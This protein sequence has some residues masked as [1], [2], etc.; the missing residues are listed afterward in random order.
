MRIFLF[1]LA[2]IALPVSAAPKVVASVLPL[3]SLLSNVMQGVGE[4]ELL[5]PANQSPHDFHLRPSQARQLNHADLVV[6]VGNDL[7][8]SLVKPIRVLTDSARVL[9]LS[10]LAKM[11]LLA[12]REGG[13][14]EGHD[15]RTGGHVHDHDHDHRTDPHFWLSPIYAARAAQSMMQALIDLDPDHADRYRSNTQA[16]LNRLADL[17]DKIAAQLASVADTPYLVFHDAYQYF[18][19]RYDLNAVGSITLK[20]GTTPGA[21]R[22]AQLRRKIQDTG[23][24][25]L[26]SEPQFKSSTLRALKE[27]LPIGL[28]ELDPLGA[29]Q[30]PGPEAY[31][32]LMDQLSSGL[33]ACFKP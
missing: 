27:G 30:T 32:Q 31:F 6:W 7:E 33:L 23:A 13:D 5:I 10:K 28:G 15:H 25:C 12:M 17:D 24:V 9:T 22:L 8:S 3:H 1:L 29:A 16:L 11:N 21:K 19:A 20:P 14:W 4:P 26:F 2:F 18:E